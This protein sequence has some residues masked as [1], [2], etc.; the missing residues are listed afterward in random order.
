MI[1]PVLKSPGAKWRV[2]SQIVSV[3]P[4]HDIYLEP[5]FG[6]GA[7]LFSKPPSRVETVND[8]DGEVANLFRVLRDPDTRER[9][10]EAAKFTPWA[11]EELWRA[12]EDAENLGEV[13]RARRLVARSHMNIGARQRGARFFRYAGLN[14]NDNPASAWAKL[15]SRIREAGERL[16][17]VQVLCRD[18]VG[19]VRRHADRDVLVYADPPYPFETRTGHGLLYR[20]EMTDADHE[21]LLEALQ[22]HPGPVLLSGFQ[23]SLY[24]ETLE[25][26][27]RVSLR[28]YAQSHGATEEVLWMNPRAASTAPNTL[29]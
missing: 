18:A 4:R 9:L 1:A 26:W 11:E 20:H 2:A 3:M 23:C 6:S 17:G 8:I 27:S 16:R 25:A 19:V 7:V 21:E 13:E 29:F 22:A 5:Y 14:S 12:C 24:E 10:V 28:G 15:S